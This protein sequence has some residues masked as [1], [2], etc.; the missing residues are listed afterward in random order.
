MKMKVQVTS[1]TILSALLSGVA[2]AGN[3]TIPNTF[4]SNTKAVA[5]EVNANFTAV[6]TAV[7]DNQAQINALAVTGNAVG[8]M[9]YW[10]GSQW[11]VLDAP[12]EANAT[13]G[14]CGGKPS[15]SCYKVGDT[16]PGGG[17]VFLINPDGVTGLEAAPADV[18]G[19]PTWGCEAFLLNS[20]DTVIG[21]GAANTAAI[22]SSCEP[23][24]AAAAAND[25]VFGGKEDWYLPSKDELNALYLQKD[26]VGGFSSNETNAYYWSSSEFDANNAWDQNF[27]TGVQDS[28]NGKSNTSIRVRAIRSF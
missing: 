28:G 4:T 21:S 20:T 27:V 15:W 8:D 23:G 12:T 16:G 1:V 18:P 19:L 9:Q 10:D 13:L 6:Q 17:I 24:I 3:L 2:T 25:F 7:D 26:K 11:V 5:S 22:V 14:F